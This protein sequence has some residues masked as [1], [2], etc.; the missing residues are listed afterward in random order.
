[1]KTKFLLFWL[2]LSIPLIATSQNFRDRFFGTYTGQ[3]YQY[4]IGFPMDTLGS[5]NASISLSTTDTNYIFITLTDTFSSHTEDY[6]LYTDSTFENVVV[7]SSWYGFFYDTD[8]IYV[9]FNHLSS[10]TD[11]FYGKKIGTGINEIKESEFYVFP[12]P[13]S[14]KLT[15][16]YSDNK[17]LNSLIEIINSTGSIVRK[18]YL[19]NTFGKYEMDISTLSNGLYL[20]KIGNNESASSKKILIAK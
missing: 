16:F 3:F 12:N 1:M 6:L 13:A 7:P 14:T 17:K 8:S 20:L 5:G 18:E 19:Q 4:T 9:Y 11:Y 10:T 15:I 2:S